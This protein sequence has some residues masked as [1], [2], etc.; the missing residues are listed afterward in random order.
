MKGLPGEVQ[1][2]VL[3]RTTLDCVRGRVG[4]CRLEL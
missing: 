4:W 2:K 3:P 1:G